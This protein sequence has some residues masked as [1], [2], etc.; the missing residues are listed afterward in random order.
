LLKKFEI[1]DDKKYFDAWNDDY[2][3]G[4]KVRLDYT[5]EWV[6]FVQN[7]SLSLSFDGYWVFQDQIKGENSMLHRHVFKSERG[8]LL[9]DYIVQHKNG[10]VWDNRMENLELK[11]IGNDVI[12]HENAYEEDDGY[13]SDTNSGVKYMFVSGGSYHIVKRM[14]DGFIISVCLKD[15][16]LSRDCALILSLVYDGV[17]YFSNLSYLV[18]EVVLRCGSDQQLE[19]IYKFFYDISQHCEG[20]MVKIRGLTNIFSRNIFLY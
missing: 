16:E 11:L 7:R 8:D 15:F 13:C 19:K 9:Y 3:D 12:F 20:T 6:E 1:S 2:E 5:R 17:D 14:F 4:Y 18:D 10:T